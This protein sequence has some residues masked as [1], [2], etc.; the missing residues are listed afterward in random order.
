MNDNDNSIASVLRDI[1]DQASPPRLSADAAWRAG[2]RRRWAP[3][4]AAAAVT[5]AAA[6]LIPL[7]ALGGTLAHPAPSAA[8]TRHRPA[9][10]EASYLSAGL[11]VIFLQWRPGTGDAISGTLTMDSPAGTAPAERLS[12]RHWPFTGTLSAGKLTLTN[13]SVTTHATIRGGTLTLYLGSLP[14][15]T[16]TPAGLTRYNAAVAALQTDIGDANTAARAAQREQARASASAKP[17]P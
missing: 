2:R 10:G 15:H 17:S 16:L 1:A 7:A 12:T 5:A 4:A 13:G 11:T 3:V 6:A 9:P 8:N 14:Y